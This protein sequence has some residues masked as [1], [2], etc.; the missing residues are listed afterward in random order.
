MHI[1]RVFVLIFLAWIILDRREQRSKS[2]NAINLKVS[3]C[4]C[5]YGENITLAEVPSVHLRRV[6][7]VGDKKREAAIW[8]TLLP[9]TLEILQNTIL[10]AL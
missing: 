2:V 8:L 4:N 5:L 1:E 7:S 10:F 9:T 3:L 6:I